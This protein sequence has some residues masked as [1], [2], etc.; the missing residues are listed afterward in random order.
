MI[1]EYVPDDARVADIGGDHALLLLHVA[2][3]GRLKKGIV[4]EI[5]RGPFE[6][7]K[8]RVAMAGFQELIEVRL[9]DGLSVLTPDEVDAVVIAGMGGTLI[10]NILEAG[11][12][13]LAKVRRLI[14]QPNI[15]A[16]RV[17][18]WLK[19]NGY[20]LTDETIVKEAGIFY[21]II[22]AEPGVEEAYKQAGLPYDIL[23]DVGPLL[24]RKRHPLLKAKLA[25]ELT[26]KEKTLKQ[27]AK[28]KTPAA[29]ERKREMETEIAEWKRVIA[30]LSGETN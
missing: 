24:W 20:R 8:K 23:L 4:G 13:K 9:G 1:A 2:K 10:A 15:G 7:A 26:G 11:K 22:V 18:G 28:G 6:N 29:E 3:K 25:A 12:T 30:C 21:E 5:N 16:R 17:R 14:L 19:E 27:L